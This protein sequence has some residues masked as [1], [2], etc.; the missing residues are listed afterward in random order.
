MR[1]GLKLLEETIGTGAEVVRG[2][3]AVVNLQLFL[4]SG[5]ELV[6]LCPPGQKTHI[7]L[8]KRE[9]IAGIRYGLEGMRVGGRRRFIISPHLAY[10]PG[11]LLDK[12]PPDTSL[13]C[14]VEVLEVRDS[15]NPAPED[16][17]PGKQL[18]I[19]HYGELVRAVPKWHF[20]LTEDGGC[21]GDLTIPLPGLKW[22]HALPKRFNKKLDPAQAAALF[23]FVLEFPHKHPQECLAE[24]FNQGGDSAL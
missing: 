9:V 10:G 5:A 12:V 2:K 7:N 4:P 3:T 1:A 18:I 20:G 13:R 14:D 21:G 17:P 19:M 11:G 23:Q 6:S 22:R 15:P 8:A 24:A 16:Y